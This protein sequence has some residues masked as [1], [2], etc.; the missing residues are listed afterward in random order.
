MW[1][2]TPLADLDIPYIE[3]MAVENQEEHAGTL[4]AAREQSWIARTDMGGY[5]ILR[6][7]DCVALLR[8]RRWHQAFCPHVRDDRGSTRTRCGAGLPS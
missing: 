3:F 1:M 8:D 7:E 5:S 2:A 6:Y 4:A